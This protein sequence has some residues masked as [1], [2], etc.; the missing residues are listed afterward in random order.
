MGHGLDPPTTKPNWNKVKGLVFHEQSCRVVIQ[1]P[2]VAVIAVILL[3]MI[4]SR[5]ARSD[6]R[7][8][9]GQYYSLT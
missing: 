3:S 9:P 5:G 8:A 4:A 2:L 7:S 1:T 6:Q